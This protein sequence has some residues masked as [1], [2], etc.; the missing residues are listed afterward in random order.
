M[1]SFESVDK[2]L[3]RGLTEFVKL[4]L[5]IHHRKYKQ[6]KEK[7]D[8]KLNRKLDQEFNELLTL[9]EKD[10]KSLLIDYTDH[11]CQKYF[12]LDRW[13]YERG[14]MDCQNYYKGRWRGVMN[15]QVLQD[16]KTDP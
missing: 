11:L 12:G 1:E 3:Q 13:F 4:R 16:E 9:L 5:K 14:L 7:R 15:C 2:T 6:E 10:K 8:Y